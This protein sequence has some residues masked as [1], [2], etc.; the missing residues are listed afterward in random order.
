ME[1]VGLAWDV[2]G[3]P[4]RIYREAEGANPVNPVNQA[5][6]VN[7]VDPFLAVT[8]PAEPS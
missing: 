8:P 4:E 1:R 5:D 7:Q 6:P 3:V 2:Q